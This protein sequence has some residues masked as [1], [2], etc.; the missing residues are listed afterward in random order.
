MI[1]L[2]LLVGVALHFWLRISLI[3]NLMIH[4]NGGPFSF[5]PPPLPCIKNSDWKIILLYQMNFEQLEMRREFFLCL[6]VSP[7]GEGTLG[8][9]LH[10]S[11]RFFN[12]VFLFVCLTTLITFILIGWIVQFVVQMF[13]PLIV[14]YKQGKFCVLSLGITSIYRPLSYPLKSLPSISL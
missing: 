5:P 12:N 1:K 10:Q 4:L 13:Q 9:L 3:T 6:S 11:P 7:G 2:N 8:S 14:I